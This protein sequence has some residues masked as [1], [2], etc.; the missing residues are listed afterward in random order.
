MEGRPLCRPIILGTRQR[1]S[2]QSHAFPPGAEDKAADREGDERSAHVDQNERPRIC[3]K[4]GEDGDRGI[5]DKQ[6]PEPTDQR[7]L[8]SS[9][10]TRRIEASDQPRERVIND[11]GGDD[12]QHV[13]TDV[14]RAL[15]ISHCSSMQIEPP[16]AKD[17]VPCPADDLMHNDQNPDR[18]MIDLRFHESLTD[19]PGVKCSIA[20]RFR[21]WSR[22][23]DASDIASIKVGLGKRDAVAADDVD[24]AAATVFKVAV[25]NLV[26]VTTQEAACQFLATRAALEVLRPRSGLR[27][28]EVV[29]PP[30][31]KTGDGSGKGRIH[32]VSADA[33][34]FRILY[35]G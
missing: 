6:E 24:L 33:V 26:A 30:V 28:R 34:R 20:S 27:E 9:K 10:R 3:F 7:D 19:Y 14:M 18:E 25:E 35:A 4:G 31:R 2:L 29:A 17:R 22:A 23:W 12:C 5:F 8:Q 11:D 1:A 16:I 32:G 13:R 15:D 21:C